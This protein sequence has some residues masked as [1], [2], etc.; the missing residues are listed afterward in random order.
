MWSSPAVLLLAYLCTIA[1]PIRCGQHLQGN[2]LAN[3]AETKELAYV[4]RL[5]IQSI[6]LEFVKSYTI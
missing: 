3:K 6:S 1:N 5:C 4:V 2:V